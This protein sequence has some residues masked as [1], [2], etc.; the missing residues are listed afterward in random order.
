MS[1]CFT[2]QTPSLCSAFSLAPFSLAHVLF[3][4]WVGFASQTL[5]LGSA[6]LFSSPLPCTCFYFLCECALP[7]KHWVC[8]VL[9]YSVPFP[10]ALAL[11]VMRVCF[12]SQTSVLCSA[13]LFSSLPLFAHVCLPVCFA[14]Q[15][16][17]LWS[18]VFPS[19]LWDF[20][21]LSDLCASW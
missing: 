18:A 1:V 17:M 7:P 21:C 6:S 10:F 9:L 12:G 5:G 8:V 14:S 16:M 15:S 4:N 3:V 19:P 11:F 2:S 13:S 20:P